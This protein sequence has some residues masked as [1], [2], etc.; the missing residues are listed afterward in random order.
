MRVSGFFSLMGAIV[1]GLIIADL[2]RNS[3]VTESL[4]TAGGSTASLLAGK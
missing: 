2:W 4:V 1:A 3:A